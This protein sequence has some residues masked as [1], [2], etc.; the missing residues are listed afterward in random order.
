MKKEKLGI[1]DLD[2]SPLL[3]TCEQEKP[4]DIQDR[5]ISGHARWP[6]GQRKK[7]PPIVSAPATRCGRPALCAS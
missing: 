4:N 3:A 7:L 2:L 5:A 6:Q 1:T